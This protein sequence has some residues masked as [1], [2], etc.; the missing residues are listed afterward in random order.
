MTLGTIVLLCI[1]HP[2][3]NNFDFE[4]FMILPKT[5]QVMATP[6]EV[7]ATGLFTEQLR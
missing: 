5:G 6:A 2:T 4:I 7:G 3:Q 1:P